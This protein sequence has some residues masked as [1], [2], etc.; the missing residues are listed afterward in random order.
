MLL[1]LYPS[2]TDRHRRGVVNVKIT[3]TGN[4][5]SQRNATCCCRSCQCTTTTIPNCRIGMRNSN[6]LKIS[7]G[8][9]Y[10]PDCKQDDGCI[11]A[12]TMAWDMYVLHT[13]FCAQRGILRQ[14]Q[15]Q[16]QQVGKWLYL[17]C[18]PRD[19]C[20]LHTRFCIHACCAEKSSTHHS[21]TSPGFG[22]CIRTILSQLS[23]HKGSNDC[24]ICKL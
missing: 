24:F 1:V 17:S 14:S 7:R 22:C 4:R 9:Q 8:M 16:P 20:T 15:P 5:L 18:S 2:Y 19:W 10:L 12:M 13:C 11:C 21:A 6:E 3:E 23:R